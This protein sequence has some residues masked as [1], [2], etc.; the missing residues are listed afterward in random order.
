MHKGKME[1]RDKEGNEG[2]AEESKETRPEPDVG[3]KK[4]ER[5]KKRR[6]IN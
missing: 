2:E 1:N 3:D 5:E 4:I 6:K